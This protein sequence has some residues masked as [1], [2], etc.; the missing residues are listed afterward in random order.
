MVWHSRQ[1]V[2]TSFFR[3]IVSSNKPIFLCSQEFRTTRS[4]NDPP[5]RQKQP[6]NNL[7]QCEVLFIV[8][9]MKFDDTRW[10]CP[11]TKDQMVMGERGTE[12]E[13]KLWHFLS[14][15]LCQGSVDY[16]LLDC[17][18]VDVVLTMMKWGVDVEMVTNI[19]GGVDTEV[20]TDLWRCRCR[21][22]YWSM[23]M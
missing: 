17:A 1:E 9:R 15:V 21:T 13:S 22:V 3:L 5:A 2:A 4:F 18:G 11:R 20:F 7:A 6:L 16:K 23:S 14:L 19:Y 8:C 10:C 12:E